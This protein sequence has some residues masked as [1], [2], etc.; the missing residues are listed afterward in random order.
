MGKSFDPVIELSINYRYE[1]K[2]RKQV[3][4]IG[5]NND[6]ATQGIIKALCFQG[7]FGSIENYSVIKEKLLK[8]DSYKLLETQGLGPDA[9]LREISCRQ[10]TQ[11]LISR[12]S[13]LNYDFNKNV[14]QRWSANVKQNLR[15]PF[16]HFDLQSTDDPIG[17][18]ELL[19]VMLL[20]EI[21]LLHINM[22]CEFPGG[23][24]GVNSLSTG[25]KLMIKYFTIFSEITARR[26]R[27]IIFLCDE[28]ENSL[29]P[30]WQK[31]FPQIM[32]TII[33]DVYGI[34]NSH[35]IFTTH[36]PLIIMR[37]A[38]LDNSFTLRMVRDEMGKIVIEPIDDVHQF[39]YENA[40]LDVFD[41]S[42]YTKME[43]S[44]C[45]QYIKSDAER[46]K[47]PNAFRGN[48]SKN[49]LKE[50]SSSIDIFQD[51]ENL[52]KS[53]TNQE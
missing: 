19:F 53:I 51:I 41:C 46:I 18:K 7:D 50:V 40:L 48:T 29:H 42:Y 9:I 8:T 11:A 28:P 24:C 20:E 12:L 6:L 30:Q 33:E 31:E 1:T 21:G 37:S 32:K 47:L 15:S 52:Y 2:E 5:S 4:H 13:S 34:R 43:Q 44:E 49:K 36:S 27:N 10:I 45:E 39:S 14:F 26:L 17:K 16:S 35:F 38:T 25:E 22:R 3:Y 23:T